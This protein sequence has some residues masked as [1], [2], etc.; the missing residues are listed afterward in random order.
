MS[1]LIEALTKSDFIIKY[2]NVRLIKI[3]LSHLEGSDTNEIH[4]HIPIDQIRI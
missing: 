1:E 4:N 3:M 2:K